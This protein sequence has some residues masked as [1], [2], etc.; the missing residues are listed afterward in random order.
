[1]KNQ[2]FKICIGNHTFPLAI[3][4]C[5]NE[6]SVVSHR[7]TD[8]EWNRF[9]VVHP[10]PMNELRYE[11][12]RLTEFLAKSHFNC[13]DRRLINNTGKS[14][15]DRSQSEF[16]A[17]F[18]GNSNGDGNGNGNGNNGPKN[19]FKFVFSFIFVCLSLNRIVRD[20]GLKTENPGL[21]GK[22]KLLNYLEFRN[23]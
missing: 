7:F 6:N 5:R 16:W 10:P 21:K 1:M 23:N 9:D 11:L 19:V 17:C 18:D 12:A 8:N 13:A 22:T 14:S 20:R 2:N 3:N 4:S 15:T